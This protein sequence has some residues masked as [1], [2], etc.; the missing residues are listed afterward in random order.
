MKHFHLS[1]FLWFLLP[2][3]DMERN[4]TE[5]H[6]YVQ[7]ITKVNEQWQ[8]IKINDQNATS[9]SP[10]FEIIMMNFKHPDVLSF[11]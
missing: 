4:Q 8:K 2:M 10:L 1:G 7:N 6:P 11:L 5:T 9:N 3:Q